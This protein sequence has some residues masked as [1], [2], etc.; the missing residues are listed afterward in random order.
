[1][2]S[3]RF[4]RD[5]VPL[6]T[7]RWGRPPAGTSWTYGS[8]RGVAGGQHYRRPSSASHRWGGRR[9]GRRRRRTPL[10]HPR[11]LASRR[12]RG[13]GRPGEGGKTWAALD[14]AVS[15]ATGRPWLDHFACPSPGP[16]LVFLG[17]GGERATVRS[18]RGHRH[19]QRRRPRPAGRP[20]AAV[21]S[22][23]QAGRPRRRLRAGRHPSRTRH[24]PGRPGHP[25]SAVS[26]RGRG[27]GQRLEPVRHGRHPPD[28]P[29]CLP[30]RGLRPVG[31]D[32]L[33]QQVISFGESAVA[34][35]GAGDAGEGEEVPG[36][37]S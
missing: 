15:V 1:M 36:F 35:E 34:D 11:A 23:A 6:P 25:R 19:R 31:G 18:H 17:E 13:P 5:G 29:G 27:R 4:D 33:E 16:V 37:R 26:G 10:A 21:L 12:L 22:S 3:D 2:T 32:P 9:P 20:A 28:H 24:P 14:L 8:D 7:G 30:A